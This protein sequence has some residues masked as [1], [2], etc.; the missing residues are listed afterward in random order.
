[1]DI[2]SVSDP[3]RVELNKELHGRPA[4]RLGAPARVSHFAYLSG[5]DGGVADRKHLQNLC[6]RYGMARPPAAGRHYVG[7]FG[8]FFLKWERHTEFTTY[9]VAV[10]SGRD[11]PFTVAA[12][13]AMPRDWVEA[14]PGRMLV[15]LNIELVD[16]DDQVAKE[17]CFT[18]FWHKDVAGSKVAGG[19][20]S[21][22]SD[23]RIH[24]DSFMRLAILADDLSEGRAGRLVQRVIEIFTYSHMALM[25]LPVAREVMAQS[26][27]IENKLEQTVSEMSHTTAGSEAEL[28]LDTLLGL[29]A[30]TE[31]QVAQSS[32]RFSAAKAYH[33][34]VERRFEEMREVR[35]PG[36]QR[37]S[38]FLDRHLA[39]AMRTC[40]AAAKRLN[41]LALRVD[42]AA[43]LLRTQVDL[44]SQRQNKELLISMNQ[45]AQLQLRLQETVEGLSVVAIS[46]YA[47][48]LA[49]VGFKAAKAAG[50][51]INPGLMTG[52]SVPFVMLAAFLLIRRIRHSVLKK[53]ESAKVSGL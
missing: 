19:R 6:D 53:G 49:G 1:M 29:A 36:S 22:W 3:L 15:A 20:S 7:D 13:E 51:P 41:D 9:T 30:R 31:H 37:L 11:I 28:H 47:I 10:R 12:V 26:S 45:R 17:A 18:P 35:I 52:I 44:D 43:G 40:E 23:F 5:E 46:Y 34:L 33:S 50:Y 25:A 48:G 27:E 16:S 4:I 38:N 24:D 32:F 39:P 8:P 21:V 42:R 14:I 2:S